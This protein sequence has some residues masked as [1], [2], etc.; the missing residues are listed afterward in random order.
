MQSTKKIVICGAGVAGIA[1][2]YYLKKMS[3]TVEITLIDKN[4]PMAFTSSK[5]GENFRD[6]WPHPSMEA[7]SSHSI[8]LMEDLQK[9]FGKD[10]F[11]MEF[12][13]YHFVSHQAE[14]PI[15]ADDDAP[16]FRARN[17]VTTDAA[18][19]H[20]EHPYL[21]PDIQKSVFIKKA[22][23]VDSITMGNMLLKIAKTEGLKLIEGEITDI[24]QN[25][26]GFAIQLDNKEAIQAD[27]IILAAGP[28]I[29]HLAG[30]L[31]FEFPVWNTL[32][33]KFLIPDPK[34]VIPADMPFTIYSDGQTL[35]WSDEEKAFFESE[36]SLKWLT[37]EFPGAIHIKPESGRIKMG[38]A[39]STKAATPQWAIP[40][41]EYFPQAVLKG[42][43]RFIPAL[44][45][46][47]ENMPTPLIEYGGYYTRTKENW[48]LVGPTEMEHVFVVGA[49][50]GFGSMTACAV[51]ELCAQYISGAALPWYADY[52][53]PNRYNNPAMQEVL[54]NLD[55]DGQL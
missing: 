23:N 48:P 10:A 3:P 19:I 5:S 22:G 6:Y 1:T 21:A 24:N 29:N 42:A 55:L 49:L 18:A 8:D 12:S 4:Q 37:Q 53:H 40:P 11:R 44:A 50:A 25:D 38:W 26:S 2:A 16:E 52:F 51:G 17:K 15:F 20:Q 33:R 9:E 46:Y 32:Q 47:A 31:S 14:K 13:G 54:D 39:F 35:G 7:L 41:F 28:F 43:S 34:K 27:K 45:D 30:M 36:D